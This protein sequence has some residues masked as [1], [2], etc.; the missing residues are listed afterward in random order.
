MVKLG[1]SWPRWRPQKKE[2]ARNCPG[3]PLPL[4]WRVFGGGCRGCTSGARTS[5]HEPPAP[6]GD[7]AGTSSSDRRTAAPW[8]GRRAEQ[9]VRPASRRADA[10]TNESA[11][12]PGKYSCSAPQL[13]ITRGHVLVT[14]SNL[15]SVGPRDS[16]PRCERKQGA[17]LVKELLLSS[18]MNTR[19]DAKVDPCSGFPFKE[20]RTG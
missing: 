6:F 7:G 16:S 10:V 1:G 12:R 19:G 13:G 2:P 15:S 9:R 3:G 8:P 18:E 20:G 11:G 17:F 14:V 5:C 4:M